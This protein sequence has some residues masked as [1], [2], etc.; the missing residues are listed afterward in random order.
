LKKTSIRM[1]HTIIKDFK[2]WN[3]L[4]ENAGFLAEETP[5]PTAAATAAGSAVG[6]AGATAGTSGTAGTVA[7]AIAA[8]L[9]AITGADGAL[10]ADDIKKVQAVIF[11]APLTDT[12]SCD[13]KVGPKTIAKI[14]EFRTANGITDET[15]EPTQT[16][17]GPKTL[18][19]IVEKIAAGFTPG[20]A[21]NTTG[22]S[23]TAGSAG[24][25]GTAAQADMNKCSEIV[26]EIYAAV[27]GPG[28]KEQELLNA[29][30]KISS[31][32]EYTTVEALLKLK[33]WNGEPTYVN[34]LAAILNGEM[35]NNITGNDTPWVD[36]IAA[37]LKTLGIELTYDKKSDNS[38]E[39]KTIKISAPVAPA[40]A[41]T[42]PTT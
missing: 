36:Q 41:A 8:P 18:A 6:A 12:I 7:P 11:N 14:K 31:A 17:I 39:E 42:T 24:T 33:Q 32:A 25:A 29:I 21:N 4:M 20:G 26:N 23:G 40:P 30:K 22:S 34:G 10:T 1:K 38:F 9:T 28:T 19:K 16:A 3:R 13:G 27:I 37:H 15:T 5:A 35:D 2:G